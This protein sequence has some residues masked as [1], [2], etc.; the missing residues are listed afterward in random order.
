LAALVGVF[1]GTSLF[2]GLHKVNAGIIPLAPP[3]FVAKDP[4]DPCDLVFRLSV[5]AAGLQKNGDLEFELHAGTPAARVVRVPLTAGMDQQQ[6]AEAVAGALRPFN[7][8]GD[9]EVFT[10]APNNGRG[11]SV[12]LND[13]GLL[14]L[15]LKD[16][17]TGLTGGFI[18]RA[19]LPPGVL[20]NPTPRV[21]SFLRLFSDSSFSGQDVDGT[22]SR[23]EGGFVF[24]QT[25]ISF[26]LAFDE[27]IAN[28]TSA[29]ATQAF[30]ILRG[31]LDPN[32]QD[33]LVLNSATGQI[34]FLNPNGTDV[35]EVYFGTTDMQGISGGGL[36]VVPEPSVWGLAMVGL[37]VGAGFVMRRRKLTPGEEWSRAKLS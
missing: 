35:A 10:P 30:G 12:Y 8:P 4:P 2:D 36:E 27:L 25:T 29:L 5:P 31:Q 16:N 21:R 18:G 7:G 26:D 37:F 3:H 28:S 23:F 34:E 24:D 32:L 6:V 11:P 15:T 20:P 22:M 1:V 13:P 14:E 19:K 9:T 17:T 33:R